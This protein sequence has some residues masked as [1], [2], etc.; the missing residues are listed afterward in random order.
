MDSSIY[1]NGIVPII[2]GNW[3]DT[4]V[5]TVSF[6]VIFICDLSIID[7]FMGDVTLRKYSTLIMGQLLKVATTGGMGTNRVN[8]SDDP[9]AISTF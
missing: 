4:T 5:L 1:L 8:F 6:V 3:A 2:M 9:F 7:F